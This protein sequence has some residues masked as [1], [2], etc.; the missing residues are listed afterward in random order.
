LTESPPDLAVGVV[1]KPHG[2]DGSFHVIG[3]RHGVLAVGATVTIAGRTTEL[4][5][6]S[7]TD[8][9]P[10][11]RVALASTREAAMALRGEELRMTRDAVGPLDEEEFW[12][13]DLEGCAVVDGERAVGTVRR[14]L[15]LPSCDVLEVARGDDPDLLVPLVHD[16]VRSVDMDARRIDVDLAFLGEGE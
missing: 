8:D 5:R 16:A 14:M 13:Q 1:G 12:A 15:A 3:P 11:V 9:R 10:I 4:A 6:V 2:L 7:G